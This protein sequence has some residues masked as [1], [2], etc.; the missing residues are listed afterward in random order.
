MFRDP[1][2]G[3]RVWALFDWDA[4]GWQNFVSDP[5]S[6]RSCKRPGTRV[7]LR[8][9]SSAASTTPRTPGLGD[10]AEAASTIV[11]TPQLRG[12]RLF[13]AEPPAQLQEVCECGRFAKGPVNERPSRSCA[14]G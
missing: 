14:S 9:R 8:R 7:S 4:E 1:N 13:E 2:E 5:E 12:F 3:D 6:L 11:E 10:A